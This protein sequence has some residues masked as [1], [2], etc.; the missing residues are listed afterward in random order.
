MKF[1]QFLKSRVFWINLLLSV[2]ILFLFFVLVLQS[3][4]WYTHHGESVTVPSLKSMSFN[5]AKLKLQDLH[6]NFEV[7]DSAFDPKRAPLSI[8]DQSPAAGSKVKQ[9][10]TIY[11][12]INSKTPPLREVPD[13]INKSSLKFAKIQ[14]ESR[15]FVLGKLIYE[16]HPDMNAVIDMKYNGKSITKNQR[17]PIGSTIDLVLGNGLGNTRI[18]VPLL[19][20]LTLSEA[21]FA[22]DAN[23]LALGAVSFDEAITDSSSA[24]IYMQI[25]EPGL[26]NQIRVGEPIDLF[27]KQNV[28]QEEIDKY[29]IRSTFGADTIQDDL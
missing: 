22:I 16:P 14:L 11:L 25:P 1:I 5:E 21:K 3:L 10:R 29:Q 19:I 28:S 6:L 27:L 23:G 17:V 13:L 24:K 12:T 4:K 15:G 2:I 26:D 9:S 20:G 18:D 8:L 7:I